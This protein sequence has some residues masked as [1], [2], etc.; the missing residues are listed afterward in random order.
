MYR[1]TSELARIQQEWTERLRNP[2][3]TVV[4]ASAVA[5]QTLGARINAQRSDKERLEAELVVLRR[6]NKEAEHK[7]KMQLELVQVL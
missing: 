3:D 6:L 4:M 7:H 2:F 1:L 5:V